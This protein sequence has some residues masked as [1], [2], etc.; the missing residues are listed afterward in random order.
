[1]LKGLKTHKDNRFSVINLMQLE[2]DKLILQLLQ[3][4]RKSES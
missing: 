3:K 1:M 2:T 4:A